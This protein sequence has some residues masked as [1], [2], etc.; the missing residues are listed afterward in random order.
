[1]R[2]AFV[3]LMTASPWGASEVLWTQTAQRALE[4]GHQVFISASG[5]PELAKELQELKESDACIDL[6]TRNRWVRRSAWLARAVGVFAQLRSFRPDVICLNQGGTY[7]ITRSGSIAELR[8]VLR[9]TATPTV[10]LCHCEQSPPQRGIHSVRRVF[11][12]IA[13]VGF[14]ARSAQAV[15]ERHLDFTLSNARAFQNPVNVERGECLPW[16]QD[17]HLRLAYVGRLEAVKNLHTLIESL[18]QRAWVDRS[19]TLS[20]FGEGSLRESLERA[21]HKS[22]LP[23]KVR[24][25]GY[26]ADIRSVWAHHHVLLL[27]SHLEGVPSAMIEAMLC[28]RPVVATNTG[29]I[30]EWIHDGSNGFLIAGS[31]SA[32]VS[33]TLE[34]VWSQRDQL[35]RMGESAYTSACLKRDPDPPGTLLR[36]LHEAALNGA[37]SRHSDM[38]PG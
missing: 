10:L 28:G 19:W 4:A 20:L 27:P 31:S 11:Q 14:T 30:A 16:P 6:R 7:D 9:S 2:I 18:S 3:S 37:P 5:W 17:D 12:R 21:V 1:M 22:G 8:R 35:Q 36:W 24:F 26:V 13:I 34:R 15:T 38:P 33:N 25:A 32:A 23:G 29:G